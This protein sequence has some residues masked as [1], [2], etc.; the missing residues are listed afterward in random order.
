MFFLSSIFLRAKHELTSKVASES[1][2]FPIIAGLTCNN[3]KRTLKNIL[4]DR[5]L[6]TKNNKASDAVSKKHHQLQR[7][8]NIASASYFWLG[9]HIAFRWGWQPSSLHRS[10]SEIL[11]WNERIWNERV[12]NSVEN[13]WLGKW[14]LKQSTNHSTGKDCTKIG[15]KASFPNDTTELRDIRWRSVRTRWVFVEALVTAV[16]DAPL[17]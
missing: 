9:R 13:T 16:C 5:S 11:E 3:R 4:L 8:N 15:H 7:D 14:L 10:V 6:N 12:W 17:H 1:V 2:I